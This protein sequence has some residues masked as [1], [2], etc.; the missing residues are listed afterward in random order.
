MTPNWH[1]RTRREFDAAKVQIL[2]AFGWPPD[3]PFRELVG[4][5]LELKWTYLGDDLHTWSAGD[6]YVVLDELLA[7]DYE[8]DAEM[9]HFAPEAMVTFCAFLHRDER[10][11]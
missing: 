5:F 10:S 2:D 3:S 9:T 8:L 4:M 1:P 7:L 6:V 11:P